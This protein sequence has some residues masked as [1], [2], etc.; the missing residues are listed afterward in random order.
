MTMS[1]YYRILEI[2]EDSTLEDI[3]KAYRQ[4]ARMYHPD[5]NHSPEA[6]DLFI[7]ATEAY[8]FLLANHDRA[9]NNEEAFR[10]AMEEWRKYRQFRSR[11]R[12]N[13]YAQAS[14]VRFKATKF[15]RTTRIF[16]ATRIIY[17]LILSVIII[18]YTIIGYIYR[19]RHPIPYFRNPSL[20]VFILLLILGMIFFAVSLTYLKAYL[21]TSK[22]HK[23]K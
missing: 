19:L 15:Y 3:K 5:I 18:L 7:R 23:K 10:Q 8:E 14:Y 22:K 11:Q 16:D 12:A 17:S 4:K 6:K 21:E 13:A 20:L 9:A 1:D 2:P